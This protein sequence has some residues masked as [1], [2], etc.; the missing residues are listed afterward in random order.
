MP[1]MKIVYHLTVLCPLLIVAACC[2]LPGCCYHFDCFHPNFFLLGSHLPYCYYYFCFQ[3]LRPSLFLY[4]DLVSEKQWKLIL[5]LK[6]Q[7]RANTS[8]N[9][10]G[11]VKD[12]ILLLLFPVVILCKF[13]QLA[14]FYKKIL[15]ELTFS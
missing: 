1:G 4:F 5:V 2:C 13:T 15:N 6:N 11:R 9:N 10:Y 3:F 8:V 7:N 12:D 14:K